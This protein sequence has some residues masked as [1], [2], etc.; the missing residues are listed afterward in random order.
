MG[1]VRAYARP[2]GALPRTPFIGGS[3]LKCARRAAPGSAPDSVSRFA[4][5]LRRRRSPPRSGGGH[6]PL[7]PAGRRRRPP[8]CASR[9]AR[10]RFAAPRP[11]L[12]V[13]L[14]RRFAPPA[15]PALS[16]RR[17]VT[18]FLRVAL[19]SCRGCR[20]HDIAPWGFI[21]RAL[22]GVFIC[23][24][25]ASS[26]LRAAAVCAATRAGSPPSPRRLRGP[27]PL[28]GVPRVP[29]P[30]QGR[31]GYG[32]AVSGARRRSFLSAAA[33]GRT[34]LRR[35]RQAAWRLPPFSP[36]GA[37][38]GSRAAASVG[39]GVSNGRH[40]VRPS[41]ARP[42]RTV[43]PVRHSRPTDGREFCA[44]LRASPHRRQAAQPGTKIKT[45]SAV[46]G[47]ARASPA[48]HAPRA[49][50]IHYVFFRHVHH[51]RKRPKSHATTATIIIYFTNVR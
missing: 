3:A 36:Q 51:S 11:R 15:G 44:A 1:V 20:R 14:L 24:A 42:P 6:P 19:W 35:G 50:P 30:R 37:P 31:R 33:S 49:T 5:R 4:R 13:P 41:R 21:C 45:N 8:P 40:S 34:T 38:A 16:C 26:A 25:A 12:A 48:P 28:V 17:P 43:A 7:A 9:A 10:R 27:P 47:D 46:C 2:R 32:T 22:P 23:Y 39:R 29:R 18:W